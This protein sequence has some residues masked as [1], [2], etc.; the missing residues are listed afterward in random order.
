M[1]RR[2]RAD[3]RLCVCRVSRELLLSAVASESLWLDV[4]LVQFSQKDFTFFQEAVSLES[5]LFPGS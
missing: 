5:L 1:M 2:V 4:V 3:V